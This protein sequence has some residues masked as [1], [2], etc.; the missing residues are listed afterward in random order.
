M[1]PFLGFL[2][3]YS[4]LLISMALNSVF[5]QAD[6]PP[7]ASSLC[8]ENLKQAAATFSHFAH[9][10]GRKSNTC[11]GCSAGNPSPILSNTPTGFSK[12]TQTSVSE[13][14]KPLGSTWMRFFLNLEGGAS[15]RNSGCNK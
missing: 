8:K 6:K 13:Y 12:Q 7:P 4:Y 9:F 5:A 14:L 11:T 10:V 2:N 1:L 3:I 15:G